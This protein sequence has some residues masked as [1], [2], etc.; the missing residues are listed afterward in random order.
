MCLVNFP[1]P[2]QMIEHRRAQHKYTREKLP[3]DYE[4]SLFEQSKEVEVVVAED[5]NGYTCV[6]KNEYVERKSLEK[7]DPKV[8]EFVKAEAS[9]EN[10]PTTSGRDLFPPK[11]IIKTV[12]ITTD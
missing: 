4:S 5:G 1:S 2:A 7:T 6:L 11:M 10:I 12:F 9:V 3:A 8:V